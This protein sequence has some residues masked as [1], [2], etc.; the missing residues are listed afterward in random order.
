MLLWRLYMLVA[1]LACFRVLVT[2]LHGKPR[3]IVLVLVEIPTTEPTGWSMLREHHLFD[4]VYAWMSDIMIYIKL[5]ATKYIDIACL[6]SMLSI[7]LSQTPLEMRNLVC[8]PAYLLGKYAFGFIWFTVFSSITAGILEHTVR[9]V[10]KRELPGYSD[11]KA[12][13]LAIPLG[14][15]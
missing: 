14:R 13:R 8:L 6:V 7:I 3:I 15:F 12:G 11:V 9:W 10:R 4:M 1:L 5:P 2:T